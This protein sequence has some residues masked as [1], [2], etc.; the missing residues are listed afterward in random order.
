MK[1][2]NCFLSQ[3]GVLLHKRWLQSHTERDNTVSKRSASETWPQWSRCIY[4]RQSD[5]RIQKE[6]KAKWRER[7]QK[8]F[9]C[10]CRERELS[11]PVYHHQ[12]KKMNFLSFGRE[13]VCF[14]QNTY[15]Y[16]NFVLFRK[17]LWCFCVRP[18]V[19][20]FFYGGFGATFRSRHK[21]TCF[22]LLAHFTTSYCPFLLL[23][24]EEEEVV[25]LITKLYYEYGFLIS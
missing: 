11:L 4:R 8:A 12:K 15:L 6:E 23:L 1:D 10:F 9:P 24:R 25:E 19:V 13:K 18:F 17:R 21:T 7:S 3:C 2:K 14:W 5:D 20:P 22:T 16:T